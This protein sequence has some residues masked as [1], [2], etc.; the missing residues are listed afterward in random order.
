MYEFMSKSKD[1]CDKKQGCIGFTI[2]E[3]SAIE[4]GG[5][6]GVMMSKQ[7]N[8]MSCLSV[9]EDLEIGG[10]HICD[11]WREAPTPD[12]PAGPI[13]TLGDDGLGSVTNYITGD[14]VEESRGS[15]CLYTTHSIFEGVEGT[16]GGGS[17]SG[18]ITLENDLVVDV[19]KPE[20]VPHTGQR[21]G[22]VFFRKISGLPEYKIQETGNLRERFGK[23]AISNIRP[24]D[25]EE[26]EQ[27][28]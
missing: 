12:N 8:D 9:E 18:G 28:R 2:R 17:S 13:R 16:I 11:S 1:M 3:L 5:I 4:T 21:P 19:F 20:Y 15:S 23:Q 10:A 26:I 14:I 7:Q 25:V 27:R 24:E 6:P 22:A